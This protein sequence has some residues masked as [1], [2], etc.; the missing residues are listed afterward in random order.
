MQYHNKLLLLILTLYLNFFSGQQQQQYSYQKLANLFDVYPE[1][2]QRALVFVQ[3]YIEKAR[4]ENNLGK[5]IQGYEEALYYNSSIKKKLNYSDSAIL[6]AKQSGN[7]DRISRA[8]LGKGIV[9]YYNEKN[10]KKALNE[11][12]R[13][14]QFAADSKDLYQKNKIVYHL[15]LVKYY[16]GYYSEA[17]LFF[18]KCADYF[19]YNML[20]SALHPTLKQNHESGYYN[21]IYRLSECYKNMQYYRKEDS[22]I[23]IGLAGTEDDRPYSIDYAYFQKSKGIQLLRM[24]KTNDALKYLRLSQHILSRKEDYVTLATVNFYLGQLYWLTDHRS[25]SLKYFTKVDSLFNAFRFITPE[26]RSN[27]EYLIK[28]AKRNGDQLLQLYYTNQLLKADSLINNDFAFLSSKLH[29]EYDTNTLMEEK[30]KLLED[31][32]D[33][34]L[35]LFSASVI[36]IFTV[37]L[38]IYIWR[39]KE[40]RL[41][42]RYEQLLE[43]S[44]NRK[45]N[46]E[47]LVSE[48]VKN[49]FSDEIVT[50]VKRKLKEF[51]D[52]KKFLNKNLKLPDVASAIGTNRTTLS[53]VLNDHL[54]VSFTQYIKMLRIQYITN[55]LLENPKYLR[56]NIDSLAAECGMSNRQVFSA[57]FLE[58][59]GIRPAD[60]IRKRLEELQ[61]TAKKI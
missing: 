32:Q 45:E 6:K 13:A 10:Y 37:I 14:Y 33:N 21:S 34:R 58:I 61:R 43:K 9:Y 48:P 19:Q 44:R 1:N 18:I 7:A 56:Y 11:Y 24:G 22:L 59:N 31:K 17:S 41:T 20:S 3:M 46:S 42:L 52:G 51:E 47:E 54:R 4:K 26:I 39:Q 55:L 2:D 50:D 29:R 15:G 53:Y 25:E 23:N 38:F 36:S 28:D 35:V 8:Y 60:F 30:N 49:I 57:H 5:L 12:L 16:L 27:Y 40:K